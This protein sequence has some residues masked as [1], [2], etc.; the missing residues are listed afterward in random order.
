MAQ[1]AHTL[2]WDCKNSTTYGCDWARE[3]IP[4]DGWE[5]TE[6]KNGYLIT[7]CP[8][9]VRDS[10]EFGAYRT[11]EEYKKAIKNRR[12]N[13]EYMH[14]YWESHKRSRAENDDSGKTGMQLHG[15]GESQESK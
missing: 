11:E 14:N 9:F 13:Y 3:F 12:N 5:A 1:Y 15:G 2:C 4:V 6:T 7:N 8:E 10:W